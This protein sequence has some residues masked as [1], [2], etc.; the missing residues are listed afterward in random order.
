M[1]ADLHCDLLLYLAGNKGRTPFD[2]VVRCSIPQMRAGGVKIQIL[3]IFTQTD[4][5]SC[6]SGQEQNR[7]FHALP[8]QFSDDF[9]HLNAAETLSKYPHKTAIMRSIE[10]ASAFCIEKEPLEHG[11]Q[12]LAQLLSEGPIAYIS[13]TWNSQNRFGGGVDSNTG[14]TDDGRSLLNFISQKHVAVDLSHT[15]DYLAYDILDH[16]DKYALDIPVIASHSNCRTITNEPRN[17]PDGLIKEIIAR[18]GIIGLN[19]IKRFLGRSSPLLLSKHLENILKYNGEKHVC[20]GADFFFEEDLPLSLRRPAGEYFFDEL[21]HSGLY[22][23]ALDQWQKNLGAS[24]ELLNSIAYTT[25]K[26]FL[27]RHILND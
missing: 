24:T 14:I 11:L 20:F 4:A 10:N 16:I 2:S 6:Q 23:N 5:G 21:A 27:L 19:F 1:I 26:D 15:S 9:I 8:H 22:A 13:L 17:L 7:L 12:R 18:N 3:P 25:A